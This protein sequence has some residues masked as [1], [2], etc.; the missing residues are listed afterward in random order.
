M[1]SVSGDRRIEG[2]SCPLCGKR[3]SWS[4][5]GP[6]RIYTP[7]PGHTVHRLSGEYAGI[8]VDS[9]PLEF[10]VPPGLFSLDL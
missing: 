2:E 4:T 6:E 9:C 1:G 5:T 7:P 8:K 10:F 3:G